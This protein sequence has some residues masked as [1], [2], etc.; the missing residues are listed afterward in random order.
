MEKIVEQ[1]AVELAVKLKTAKK[2]KK[3]RGDGHGNLIEN[4]AVEDA[5]SNF[6]YMN[7]QAILDKSRLSPYNRSDAEKLRLLFGDIKTYAMRL[8]K[9]QHWTA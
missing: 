9:A 4:R 1:Y 8:A 2:E 6:F 3:W 5:V 7:R